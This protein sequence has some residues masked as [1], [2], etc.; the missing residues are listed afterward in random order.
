MG[1]TVILFISNS[2]AFAQSPTIYPFTDLK[3]VIFSGNKKELSLSKFGPLCVERF[4]IQEGLLTNVQ[5]Y[6]HVTKLFTN[7]TSNSH[8]YILG[9]QMRK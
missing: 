8:K 2:A 3:K 1:K 6:I 4:K 7:Q 5:E 9:Q